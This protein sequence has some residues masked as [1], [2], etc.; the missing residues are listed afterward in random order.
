MIGIGRVGMLMMSQRWVP[1]K[2]L[3]KS[4]AVLKLK[5]FVFELKWREVEE[6]NDYGKSLRDNECVNFNLEIKAT[7]IF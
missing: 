6:K 5:L 2:V 1:K 7:P 3:L 4:L